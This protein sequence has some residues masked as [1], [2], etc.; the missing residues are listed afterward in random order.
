MKGCTYLE[1]IYIISTIL[2]GFVNEYCPS[3]LLGNTFEV[4]L[5][6]LFFSEVSFDNMD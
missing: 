2:V 4:R 6:T 5:P 1:H 3:A